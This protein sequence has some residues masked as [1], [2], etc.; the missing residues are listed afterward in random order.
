ME[1]YCDMSG[2]TSVT[3]CYLA[4]LFIPDALHSSSKSFNKKINMQ[5]EIEKNDAAAHK[6]WYRML[7]WQVHIEKIESHFKAVCTQAE[8]DSFFEDLYVSRNDEN[9]QIQLFAGSH[10]IGETD[11]TID[12]FGRVIGH[13][14]LSE[15]GAALVLSQSIL[16]CVAVTLYPYSSERLSRIQPHIT[17]SILSDPTQITDSVL[18][19]A[20]R[21]FFCYMRVSSSVLSDNLLDRLRIR[22]LE[23]RSMKYNGGSFVKL[24]FSHWSWVFLGAVGSIASIYSLL[25]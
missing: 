23:L 7:N 21:D 13:R 20:T 14:I 8:K 24:V 1:N 5:T 3:D 10:P 25:K 19:S 18:K 11:E 2:K 22:Y 9:R 6:R 12:A 17:W 4:T 15:Q 16:G